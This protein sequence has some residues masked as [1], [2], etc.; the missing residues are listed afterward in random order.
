[1]ADKRLL[2]ERRQRRTPS[3]EDAFLDRC[4]VIVDKWAV[5]LGLQNWELHVR[6]ASGGDLDAGDKAHVYCD[7]A[8]YRFAEITMNL[9]RLYEA[10]DVELEE[11]LVHEL[12]HVR[13]AEFFRFWKRVDKKGR[14]RLEEALVCDFTGALTRAYV[15]GSTGE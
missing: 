11:V 13:A 1:M 3:Q 9:R 6:V 4:I 12:C 14:K 5:I 15:A 2:Q 10:D 7:E 8:E